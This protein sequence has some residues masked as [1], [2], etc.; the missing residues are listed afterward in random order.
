MPV[1]R[2]QDVLDELRLEHSRRGEEGR[3]AEQGD[4]LGHDHQDDAGGDEPPQPRGH[5]AGE[6][7][8]ERH[9]EA[10]RE[11]EQ[12]EPAPEHLEAAACAGRTGEHGVGRLA[13][14]EEE[15]A[16]RGMGIGSDGEPLDHVGALLPC[17]DRSREAR[18]ADGDGAVGDLAAVGPGNRDPVADRLRVLRQP[19]HDGAGCAVEP[20]AGC[21]CRAGEP[22]VCVR[23]PG[24]GAGER[25]DEESAGDPPLHAGASAGL[26]PAGAASARRWVMRITRPAASKEISPAVMNADW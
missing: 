4:W 15:R 10:E 5:P 2:E 17:V 26:G 22:G 9:A 18:R 20:R 12:R 23:G 24:E 3:L 1:A 7:R 25:G 21:R 19:D 6:E 14:T 8:R 13:D 11:S 16:A